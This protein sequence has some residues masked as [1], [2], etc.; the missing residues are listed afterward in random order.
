MTSDISIV[1]LIFSDS[2]VIDI[3]LKPMAGDEKDKT[4]LKKAVRGVRA[5]ICLNVCIRIYV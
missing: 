2:Y 1:M 3:V 4:F 5:L